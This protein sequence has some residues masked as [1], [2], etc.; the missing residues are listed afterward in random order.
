MTAESTE[1][2][3]VLMQGMDLMSILYKIVGQCKH[4]P[5]IIELVTSVVMN[6]AMHK[7][8]KAKDL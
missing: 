5:E 4:V 2:S 3:K 1:N 8:I 6:V 7:L